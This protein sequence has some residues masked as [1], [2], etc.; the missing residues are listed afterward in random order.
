M[1]EMGK[2]DQACLKTKLRFK[3]YMKELY[4]FVAYI[5]C[6]LRAN[7]LEKCEEV[8]SMEHQPPSYSKIILKLLGAD[9]IG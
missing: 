7:V 4:H 6:K 8:M 3:K 1:T 9:E 5:E 2:P